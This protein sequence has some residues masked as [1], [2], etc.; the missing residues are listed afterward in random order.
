MHISISHVLT[1]LA[2]VQLGSMTAAALK[3]RYAVSTVSE[4]ISSLER[5]L[6]CQLVERR[7]EGCVPTPRGRRVQHVAEEL[8]KSHETLLTVAREGCCGRPRP[9]SSRSGAVR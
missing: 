9:S 3:L 8:V 1:F 2:V 7:A 4:H 5:Q 6:G